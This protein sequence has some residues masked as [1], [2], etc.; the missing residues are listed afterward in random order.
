MQLTPF[1]HAHEAEEVARAPVTQL[2]LR[3]VFMRL[4]VVAPKIEHAHEIGLRVGKRSVRS[5][6]LLASIRRPLTRILDAEERHNG[7]YLAQA[8]Q[9]LR[10]YQH[11]RQ[12]HVDGQLG[13]GTADR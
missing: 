5:V 2:R 7:Q 4:A 11:A 3:E 12:L 10:F 13:D 8:M 1:T 6:G 9:L